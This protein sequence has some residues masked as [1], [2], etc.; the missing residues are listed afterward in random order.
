MRRRKWASLST[1]DWATITAKGHSSLCCFYESYT[2]QKAFIQV[3]FSRY[4]HIAA[5]EVLTDIVLSRR[6]F[7]E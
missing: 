5:S 7:Q 4:I 2:M 3:L 1:E 6:T